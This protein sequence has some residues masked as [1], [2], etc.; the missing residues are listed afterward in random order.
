MEE[1]QKKEW[2]KDVFD[3]LSWFKMDCVKAARVL[4]VGAGALGNEV[5]KNLALF[6]VGNI[7]IADYDTI[8]YSNLTRSVLFRE[9]DADKGYYKSEVAAR[10]VMEINPNIRVKPIVGRLDTG[11]GLGLY[12][13][14]NVVV[15]CLDS[16]MARLQLNRQCIRANIPWVDGSIENLEGL[17]RVYRRGVNCYE[18]ELPEQTKK[19]IESRVSCADVA[20]RN[21]SVGRVPTTPVIASI[22]GAVQCQE[23]MKIIHEGKSNQ[24]DFTSMCGKWFYYEGSHLTTRIYKSAIWAEDC[25][26][27]E[28]WNP[29]IEIDRLSADCTVGET[30]QLL[31]SILQVEEVEINLRNTRFVE[32]LVT[33]GDN[34]CYMVMRPEYQVSDYIDNEPALYKRLPSDINQLAYENIDCQF[35]HQNLRLIQLGIPYWDVLQVSTEKGQFFIELSADRAR[36]EEES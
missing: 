25:M 35:P 7:Y 28:E 9:E 17:A 15:G 5:L 11:V 2:G 30:L 19:K 8:E 21:I 1:K 10:R 18:C 29:V 26:A 34:K 12:R 4:V 33:K 13:R 24:H 22:I 3:L 6:G 31:R 36:Y 27:H 20:K 32:K 16:R 14:M 23:A